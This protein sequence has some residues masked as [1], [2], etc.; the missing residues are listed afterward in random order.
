LRVGTT[1]NLRTGKA[2]H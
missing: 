1:R 2:S